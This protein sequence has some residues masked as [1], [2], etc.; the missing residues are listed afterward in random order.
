MNLYQDQLLSFFG[1]FPQ[2]MTPIVIMLWILAVAR[3]YDSIKTSKTLVDNNLVMALLRNLFYVSVLIATSLFSILF[4]NLLA[5]MDTS[6]LIFICTSLFVIWG[7]STVK[8]IF[9]ILD[10]DTTCDYSFFRDY[11]RK[12]YFKRTKAPEKAEHRQ[13]KTTKAIKPPEKAKKTKSKPA[14]T[15]KAK[16]S[17]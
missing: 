16:S 3:F 13:V 9:W 8:L 17:K 6:L 10:G 4:I 15:T 12:H 2:V 14:K 5:H 7:C 11:V 1:T